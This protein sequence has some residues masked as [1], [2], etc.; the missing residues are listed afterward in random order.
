MFYKNKIMGW[1][2]KDGDHGLGDIDMFEWHP[3]SNE[4]GNSMMVDED[5]MDLMSDTLFTSITQ[6]FP[7]PNPRE[8]AKAGLAE[9][10]QPGLVQL[11][12]NIEDYMDTLEPLQSLHD[13]LCSSS[14][15]LA[16]VPEEPN[17][18]NA[19]ETNLF[20]SEGARSMDL[21]L[22]QQAGGP[23]DSFPDLSLQYSAKIFSDSATF[24]R[25]H[26]AAPSEPFYFTAQ[27]QLLSSQPPQGQAMTLLQ[28]QPD[29]QHSSCKWPRQDKPQS[30]PT[31]LCPTSTR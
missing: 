23:G 7:F 15:K 28:D 12:P 22:G 25:P 18:L 8:I 27:D 5:Y 13:L 10:I 14:S 26:S 6:P 20:R 3:D 16:S 19:L 31:L 2:P 17:S 30:R 24:Q 9:F 21:N 4:S 11:Q 29:V 1:T